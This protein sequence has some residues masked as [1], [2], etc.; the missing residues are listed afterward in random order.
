M[1]F[2]VLYHSPLRVSAQEKLLT[3]SFSFFIYIYRSLVRSF[4]RRIF[5]EP[6][7]LDGGGNVYS[8]LLFLLRE[9]IRF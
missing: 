9:R 8:V 3:I 4:S 7:T 5:F 1:I 6:I 2:W